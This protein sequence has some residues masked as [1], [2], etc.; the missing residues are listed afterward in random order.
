MSV[1]DFG[2][3]MVETKQL[4]PGTRSDSVYQFGIRAGSFEE[5]VV[6]LTTEPQPESAQASG[7]VF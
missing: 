1:I 5:E 4:S 6:P 2:D 3:A 7:R